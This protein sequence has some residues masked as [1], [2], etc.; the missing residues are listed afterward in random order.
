MA[1]NFPSLEEWDV[2]V[3]DID[4][5]ETESDQPMIRIFTDKQ[6]RLLIEPLYS[7][8]SRPGGDRPF[9]A[10]ANVGFFHTYREPA[11]VPNILLSLDVQLAGSPHAKESHSYFQW[12]MGKAPDVVIEIVSDRRG[13]EE[14]TKMRAYARLGVPF[15]LIFDPDNILDSGVLRAFG[16]MRKKYEP[17]EPDWFPEVGLGLKLWQGTFEDWT[18]TWLRWCDKDGRLIPTGKER[19]DQLAARLRELGVDPNA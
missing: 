8:W 19:A 16:L 4:Q 1:S 5:L 10:L 11:L 12:L 3:P 14:G 9:L 13:D 7:P 6:S 17:I 18:N 15:Y 2:P